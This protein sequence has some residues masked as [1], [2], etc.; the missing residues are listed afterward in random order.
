MEKRITKRRYVKAIVI[1]FIAL[2]LVSFFGNLTE[3]RAIEE[4]QKIYNFNFVY[5]NYDR[6]FTNPSYYTWDNGYNFSSTGSGAY[7]FETR[8]RSVSYEFEAVLSINKL[9]QSY[10]TLRNVMMFQFVYCN[11][12]HYRVSI[13][14]VNKDGSWISLDTYVIFGKLGTIYKYSVREAES[15]IYE[16]EIENVET[17]TVEY[18]KSFKILDAKDPQW[19]TVHM[20]R[21]SSGGERTEIYLYELTFIS[22]TCVYYS[23]QDDGILSLSGSGDD[24]YAYIYFVDVGEIWLYL[25][26]S[27]T[28]THYRD[29]TLQGWD[30]SSWINLYTHSFYGFDSKMW[31]EFVIKENILQTYVYSDGDDDGLKT[32]EVEDSLEISSYYCYRLI[33]YAESVSGSDSIEY[34]YDYQNSMYASRRS[35]DLE[36]GSSV[37][38]D[39]LNPLSWISYGI[40][41][42]GTVL[43]ALFDP[44]FSFIVNAV[45]SVASSVWGFFESL[46]N[47]IYNAILDVASSVWS[48]F[49]SVLNNIYI[50]IQDIASSVW[51]YFQGIL[52]NIYMAIQ[53]LAEWI[54]SYFQSVL[55]NIYNAILSIASDVWNA[56]ISS[57]SD[58]VNALLPYVQDFIN[59]IISILLTFLDPVL[60][61]VIFPLL[62]VILGQ[63]VRP[64]LDF[65]GFGW[66]I[67]ILV[68]LNLL[69]AI[70]V[71]FSFIPF[72]AVLM[73]LFVIFELG[74][75]LFAIFSGNLE[76]A[77][78]KIE[79]MITFMLTIVNTILNFGRTIISVIQTVVNA[80]RG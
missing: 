15:G 7:F 6:F 46:L 20:Y 11:S 57:V 27:A 72:F 73:P 17:S 64:I 4:N 26:D 66:I 45:N 80:I 2:F 77:K 78:E 54:W 34:H 14:Y 71:F 55:D 60:N 3:T 12:T 58:V 38:I 74:T 40:Y 41:V 44:L 62:D 48:F 36:S 61:T 49:E 50:A 8:M 31:I 75:I 67:D 19:I 29:I 10:A 69:N 28:T 79:G 43:I 22:D 76:Y 68:S 32:I 37:S 35:V 59:Q 39:P 47:S 42:L 70:N 63:I 18:K 56:F 23:E 51:S 16:F 33:I 13:I 5:E 25:S 52:D 65:F 24:D 21:D 53:D 30:G 9:P 1:M